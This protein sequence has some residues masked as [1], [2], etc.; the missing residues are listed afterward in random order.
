MRGPRKVLLL[1]LV[2]FLFVLGCDLKTSI[3]YDH[4]ADFSQVATYNW[5]GE[6]H[7]EINDLVHNRIM[8]ALTSQLEAKGLSKV[9]SDPDVFVT[10]YGDHDERTVV[11][12][13]SYGYGMGP[14]WGYAG[15]MGYAG[16][17]AG[18]MGG[19]TSTVSNYTEGTLVID[20]YRADEKQLIWRGTVTGTVSD[21]PKKN[22]ENINKGIVKLFEKYPPPPEKS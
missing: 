18:G 15:G 13:T 11:N 5:T 7:P 12:T 8:A 19:S 20:I 1:L 21:D 22:E 9:D 10:Y 16:M 3:D 14:G 2:P 17:G 6:Q 4:E